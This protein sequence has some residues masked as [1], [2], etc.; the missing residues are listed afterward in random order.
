MATNTAGEN[1][2]PFVLG[3]RVHHTDMV[4]GSHDESAENGIFNELVDS[5]A[6]TTSTVLRQLPHAMGVRR[7]SMWVFPSTNGW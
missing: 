4:D 3:R 5:P 2:P 6:P 7:W 1:G